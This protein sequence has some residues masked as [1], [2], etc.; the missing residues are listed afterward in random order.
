MP[1]FNLSNYT[2]QIFWMLI[3]FGILFMWIRYFIFPLYYTIFKA[4][5]LIIQKHLSQAEKINKKAEKV[6]QN[7]QQT[8][9]LT[10]KKFTHLLSKAHTIAQDE[11]QGALDKNKKKCNKKLKQALDQLHTA[12]DTLEKAMNDWTKTLQGDF[13]A[14]TAPGKRK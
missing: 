4:R 12:E 6:A 9:V 13:I 1:Q 11:M 2:G 7:L 5:E 10:E 3:S 14:K 8:N